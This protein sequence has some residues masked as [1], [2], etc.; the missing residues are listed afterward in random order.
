MGKHYWPEANLEQALIELIRTWIDLTTATTN[1]EYK[2]KCSGWLTMV[3]HKGLSRWVPRACVG[4]KTW[5]RREGADLGTAG[6]GAWRIRARR[7]L[8]R[9]TQRPDE[10]WWN[11]GA[12]LM[13]YGRKGLLIHRAQLI[14]GEVEEALQIL[15]SIKLTGE[16][17]S[18]SPWF[19]ALFIGTAVRLTISGHETCH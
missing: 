19:I 13:L 5:P 15:A 6:H 4:A 1:T 11:Y 18:A 17:V 8:R 16:M 2:S 10:L 9:G 14:C 7:C 3:K 12:T